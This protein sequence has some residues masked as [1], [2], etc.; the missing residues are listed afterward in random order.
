M[1]ERIKQIDEERARYHSM[2]SKRAWGDR[3]GYHL[4]INTTGKEIKQ[5]API[6]A[7]YAKAWLEA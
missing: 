4:C 5:L 2:V 3:Q 1:E 7:S 6:V